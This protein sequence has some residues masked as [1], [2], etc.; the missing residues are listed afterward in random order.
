MQSIGLRI[1]PE[2]TFIDMRRSYLKSAVSAAVVAAVL[3]IAPLQFGS[4]VGFAQALAAG[5]QPAN[6][7]HSPANFGRGTKDAG[8]QPNSQVDEEKVEPYVPH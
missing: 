2:R 6:G 7:S 3:A 1:Q 5:K 4:A 8:G